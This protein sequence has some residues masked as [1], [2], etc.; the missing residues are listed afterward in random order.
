MT[1]DAE[2][3]S[4][5]AECHGPRMRATRYPLRSTCAQ[6]LVNISYWVARTGTRC[7]RA[8]RGPHHAGR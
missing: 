8:Q 1:D 5:T 2:Q 6:K 3:R 4:R 7:A